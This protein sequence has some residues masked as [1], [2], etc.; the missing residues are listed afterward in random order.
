MDST[1]DFAAELYHTRYGGCGFGDETPA[2]QGWWIRLAEDLLAGVLL[3]DAE[4]IRARERDEPGNHIAS[5]PSEW[6]RLVA[7]AAEG[8]LTRR[9]N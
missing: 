3:P 5:G 2:E 1:W 8:E 9:G 6:Y 7:E 4:A